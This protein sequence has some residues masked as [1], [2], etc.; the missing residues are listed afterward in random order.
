MNEV[1][2]SIR[3]GG[4]KMQGTRPCALA[5][6]RFPA[7]AVV[8]LSQKELSTKTGDFPPYGTKIDANVVQDSGV[9]QQIANTISEQPRLI[10]GARAADIAQLKRSLEANVSRDCALCSGDCAAGFRCRFCRIP[11][12]PCHE[13]ESIRF[14]CGHPLLCGSAEKWQDAVHFRSS[15]A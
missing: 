9:A 7:N 8:C 10:I 2:T 11:P 15:G 14:G 3:P 1:S 4:P 5:R 12:A 13:S 6:I